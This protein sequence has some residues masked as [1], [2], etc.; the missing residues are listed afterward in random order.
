MLSEHKAVVPSQAPVVLRYLR[1]FEEAELKGL[2]GSSETLQDL[3]KIVIH[4]RNLYRFFRFHYAVANY[5]TCILYFVFTINTCNVGFTAFIQTLYADAIVPD[6]A[7]YI[8]GGFFAV[9]DDLYYMCVFSDRKEAVKATLFFSK[10]PPLRVIAQT[11][12]KAVK[13]NPKQSFINSLKF[14]GHQTILQVNNLTG[15]STAIIYL[16]MDF[17]TSKVRLATAVT[18]F[19][20]DIYY[21]SY[22]NE[23]Y[24]EGLEYLKKKPWLVQK[25][26]EGN[27]SKALFLR[28]GLQTAS[29][30]VLRVYP[31]M[32]YVAITAREVLGLWFPEYLVI[33]A[34]LAQSF[35]VSHPATAQ[36]YIADWEE[37]YESLSHKPEILQSAS[38][39][40]QDLKL[41][42]NEINMQNAVRCIILSAHEMYKK[43]L[44]QEG[45]V[46]YLWKNEKVTA[47]QLL[48][49]TFL[50][51]YLGYG[52]GVRLACVMNPLA[53][54][55]L[56]VSIGTVS[57]GWTFF[58]AE[59]ERIA[60][61]EHLK[62][63]KAANQDVEAQMPNAANQQK[64]N[65][66]YAAAMFLNV[67]GAAVGA[68][69]TVG[70]LALLP[71]ARIPEIRTSGILLALDQMLNS[72]HFNRG[73]IYNSVT[74]MYHSISGFYH[75]LPSRTDV[76]NAL[77][78]CSGI[79]RFF[80][81]QPAQQPAV[82]QNNAS[83]RS[84]WCCWRRG[85]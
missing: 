66:L 24:Y 34:T 52:I 50:G 1:G 59:L 30:V 41:P 79:Y 22:T 51:G 44:F 75:S 19:Y 28:I 62:K 31:Y 85:K 83:T 26:W 76:Y 4:N 78:S 12:Y 23:S 27:I 47:L 55:V 72:I 49:D 35:S 53:A 54:L 64:S 32:D 15:A 40:L 6:L 18:L 68:M 7:G 56:C 81:R 5:G 69:S 13:E 60:Y 39:L 38:L 84:S 48:L 65:R 82:N 36:H 71:V 2:K 43:N 14:L 21:G 46:R 80:K 58:K 74:D 63:E 25:L 11:A 37:L 77:P 45:G 70:T 17:S 8:I 20:G 67:T 73:K 29:A 16:P 42:E 57:F 9:V 33:F 61:S 10:L 3:D